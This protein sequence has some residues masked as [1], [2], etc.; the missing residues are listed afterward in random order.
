MKTDNYC[1][2]LVEGKANFA[3]FQALQPWSKRIFAE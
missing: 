2:L 3:L 1:V